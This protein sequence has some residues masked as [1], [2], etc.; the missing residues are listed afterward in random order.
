MGIREEPANL[1]GIGLD[2]ADQ[3]VRGIKSVE[4]TVIRDRRRIAALFEI[5]TPDSL[6]VAHA[7]LG[8]DDNGRGIGFERQHGQR[9]R[10]P[11]LL[12]PSAIDPCGDEATDKRYGIALA[13]DG[14]ATGRFMNGL[15]RGD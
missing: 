5:D 4:H 8:I 7:P 1:S 2:L 6:T 11:R 3:I 10:R 9:Q 15:G 13:D 14:G 12:W